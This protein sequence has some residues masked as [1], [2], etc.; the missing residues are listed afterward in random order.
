LKI[1]LIDTIGIGIGN[2]LKKIFLPINTEYGLSVVSVLIGTYRLKSS[3]VW[4]EVG[5]LF[6]NYSIRE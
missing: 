6:S 5:F 1:L 3:F 2:R 4:S